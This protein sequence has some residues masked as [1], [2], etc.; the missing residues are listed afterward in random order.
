M[1]DLSR[2]TGFE[3]D[4]GNDVKN[5]KKHGVSR[6]ECEEVFFHRPL[7]LQDDAVHSATEP[8]NYVLGRTSASRK[9][10]LVF[11]PR[12]DRI[13]VISARDMTKAERRRYQHEEG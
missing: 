2:F 12:G 9:L 7:L 4:A 3:W 11:T 5:W 8:R 10:F 6:T 1:L 13:R